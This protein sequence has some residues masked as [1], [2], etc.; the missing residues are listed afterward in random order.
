ML[1]DL[2]AALRS[3]PGPLPV[4][5]PLGDIPAFLAR[6]QKLTAGQAAALAPA[7]ARLT[8]ELD[9]TPSPVP[10]RRRRAPAT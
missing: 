8:A 3:Y 7:Y 2:H 4:L 10:A 9:P 6:P 5:A 1:R